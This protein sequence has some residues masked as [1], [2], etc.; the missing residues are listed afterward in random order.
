MED[1][2]LKQTTEKMIEAAVAVFKNDW[3]EIRDYA[4][5]EFKKL[6][7]TGALILRLHQ[8]GRITKAEARALLEMQKNTCRTVMLALEGMHL[9]LVEK[10]VNATM[11]VLKNAVNAAAGLAIL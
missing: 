9:L 7:D 3:P 2:N 1:L 6:A 8:A 10:A 4:E 11:K 5:V